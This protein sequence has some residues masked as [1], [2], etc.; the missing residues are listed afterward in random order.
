MRDGFKV[1]PVDVLPLL[2]FSP[3]LLALMLDDGDSCCCWFWL[4][5]ASVGALVDR[6][7]NTQVRQKE[8]GNLQ[9]KRGEKD[10]ILCCCLCFSFFFLSLLLLQDSCSQLLRFWGDFVGFFWSLFLGWRWRKRETMREGQRDFSLCHGFLGFFLMDLLSLL[11]R[12]VRVLY[13]QC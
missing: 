6:E 12:N 10:L 8:R 7:T 11:V 5:V 4:V 9:K 13:V 3:F 2:F 1:Q